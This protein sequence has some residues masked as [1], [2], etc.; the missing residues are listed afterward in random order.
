MS[1]AC[2]LLL[3]R[4]DDDRPALLFEDRRWSY[5][6]LVDEGRRRAAF[7][8]QFQTR[9]PDAGRPPHIGILL[10]N[11]PE[12]VFWLTAAAL[13][14]SVLVGINSTYRG[15]PLGQLISHT[16][17]DVVVT[18]KAH[19]PLLEDLDGVLPLDRRIVVDG[20]D[21]RAAVEGIDPATPRTVGDDALFLLIFTSGSTG[22]PK[23]V[24]CTQGRFAR[25]GAH[26]ATVT[27][28]KPEE[29]VVY[30]PLPFFH[31]ASLFSGWAGALAAAAPIATR[32]RFSASATLPDLRRHGATVLTYTGKV[33][34]YILSVPEAP[35]DAEVPLRLALG[36]EASLSDI[37]AFARRFGCAVRDS[38]GST[39]GMIVIRRDPSMPD[40][41]LGSA[42]DTVKVIDPETMREC[43]PLAVG[44]DG[45][46]AN[47]EEAVG[48]IVETAPST[49]FEGYYKNPVATSTR[50]RNGWYWSG[51]L[52][53]RDDDG[54]FYFA[55][56]SNEWLRV[57][58]ENFAAA[59][60]EMIVAASPLRPIARGLRRARRP[61]RRPRHG[62]ARVAPGLVLRPGGLRPISRGPT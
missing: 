48:E 7:H 29:D 53:Y 25:T 22:L 6:Q 37:K 24:R 47:L 8:S 1:T 51:D 41:A 46:S 55:G 62:G 18:S 30:C 36:N 54:W 16:D 39:E 26:V 59:P 28:V 10:D 38:Y 49:G 35:D 14:G 13:S 50:F 42:D 45:R 21:Y 61:G 27:D 40:G 9:F 3:A 58:G 44:A 32:Q 15:E 56:R 17:C 23:A 19:L 57:D 43:P 60:V 5:R 20:P 11:S 12:Y 31:S 33:L 4:A 2:E 34:N 52:G